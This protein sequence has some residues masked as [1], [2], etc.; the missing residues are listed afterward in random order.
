[1]KRIL[2]L[3]FLTLTVTCLYGQ[4][5]P[6]QINVIPP[7]PNVMAMNKFVDVPVGHYTGTPNISVPI[8]EIKMQQLSLPIALSYHASGLKVEEQASWVGAGWALSAGGSINRTIRGLPDEYL[9]LGSTIQPGRKGYFFNNKMFTSADLLDISELTCDNTQSYPVENGEPISTLDSLIQGHLDTEPDLYSFSFPGGSGKFVFN[10]DQEIVRVVSD[11]IK[12]TN[13]PFDGASIPKLRA[14]VATTDY[15]WTIKGAD[16]ILYTFKH[17]ERTDTDG[18][19]GFAL[20]FYDDPVLYAESAWHLDR[21]SIGGEWIQFHYVD[22]TI[23]YDM[24]VTS[25]ERFKVA[26]I[27]NDTGGVTVCTNSQ[28]VS[29][30]RLDKITTSNGYEV[31]F[32]AST[33][34]R[35]DLIGSKRLEKIEISKDANLIKAYNLEYD[36][37]NTNTKLKLESVK[38]TDGTT[39]LPGYEFDYVSGSIPAITSNSQ[40][41]WGY[42]NQAPNTGGLIPKYKTSSV[43]VDGGADRTASLSRTKIGTLEKITYPTGGHSEFIYELHDYYETDIDKTIIE[44]AQAQNGTNVSPVTVTENFTLTGTTSA[45]LTFEGPE[46]IYSRSQLRKH[47]GSFYAPYSPAIIPLGNRYSLPAGDYQLFTQNGDGGTNTATIEYE[48]D[49]DFEE[50]AGGLRVAEVKTYDPATG[51]NLIK[52][53]E[54]T[55]ENGNSSG[56]LFTPPI[57]G[58]AVIEHIGGTVTGLGNLAQCSTNGDVAYFVTVNSVNQLPSAIYQGSHIGYSRVTE[59]Q[60]DPATPLEAYKNGKTVYEFINDKGI[61]NFAFPLVPQQDVSFKNGKPLK[62]IVYK[63]DGQNLLKVSETV[64]TYAQV[65]GTESVTGYKVTQLKTRGC[66]ECYASDYG[67]NQ[68]INTSTWHYLSS[69]KRLD[70]DDSGNPLEIVT[71]YDHLNSQTPTHHLPI[72]KRW[73]NSEGE[74]IETLYTRDGTNPALILNVRTKVDG[75]LTDGQKFTYYGRLPQTMSKLNLDGQLTETYHSMISY[76]FGAGSVLL[77]EQEYPAEGLQGVNKGIVKSYIWG[78]DDAHPIAGVLNAKRDEIAYSSFE[79][80]HTG[81][82]TYS[83]TGVLN[84]DSPTGRKYYALNSGPITKTGLSTN[85]TYVVTYW[86]KSGIPTFAGSSGATISSRDAGYTNAQGWTY[87]EKTISGTTVV[88]LS[89]TAHIDELRLYP[90]GAEMRTLTYDPGVGQ[91]SESSANGLTVRYIYD[92][93]NRLSK[94]LDRDG[95]TIKLFTYSYRESIPNN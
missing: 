53:F 88:S 84:T 73:D 16:G 65:A 35:A 48:K 75:E 8:Y 69:S 32:I 37:F 28:T 49:E 19:C 70:Y 36:Y 13:H 79:A 31:K 38:Q 83:G 77:Q 82:W 11:D 45:T 91:I 59:S 54:Y 76:V 20:S 64:S 87:F 33:Q 4:E 85:K 41:F 21:M 52:K 6:S 3:T 94:I 42:Y 12:F 39:E 86:A 43:Y 58:S 78:Y 24:R 17:A 55:Q 50:T 29:A 30:K 93:F 46:T 18:G 57:L 7:S 23:S 47:N 89:G 62:Q 95:N 72:S 56:V 27:S 67:Y 25:S 61:A 74:E 22:E 1:M 34:D 81:N 5:L 10:R 80:D 26:G 15:E 68:Y 90:K 60:V 14:Q 63:K 9:P 2:I 51:Q 92:S 44:T 71:S 66:H 40:D